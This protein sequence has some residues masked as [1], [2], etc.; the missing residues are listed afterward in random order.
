MRLSTIKKLANKYELSMDV[1]LATLNCYITDWLIWVPQKWFDSI[2]KGDEPALLVC[3]TSMED[4][5]EI[6]KI[7]HL[8]GYAGVQRTCIS[9]PWI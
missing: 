8:S 6:T 2:K 3:A 4:P 5:D 7:H 1:T 9:W